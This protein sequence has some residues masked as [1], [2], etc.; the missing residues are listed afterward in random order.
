MIKLGTNTINKIYL[1]NSIVQK[2]Y[3]GSELV[4]PSTQIWTPAELGVSLALWLDADDSS[5][6]TL[7]GSTVS[8]WRDKS[9]NNRHAN[10]ATA[11]KQPLYLTNGINGR[12][13]LS[14]DGNNKSLFAS[15]AVINLPQPFSRFIAGQ[16]LSKANKSVLI[17]TDTSNNQGVFYNG[18]GGANWVVANG[19]APSFAAYS[20]GT[21]DFLNHQHM[22]IINGAAS[23]WGL[24]G[25]NI[26]GPV[27]SGPSG[28]LGVRIGHV[29]TELSGGY[30]FQGLVSEIVFVSGVISTSDRQKLEGYLAWKWGTTANLPSGHPYKINPPTI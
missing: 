19:V 4:Y 27:N 26:T 23:Y 14:F 17:D 22:H 11:A 20:Y 25:S 2:I 5:T 21:R 13:V 30:A 6:I 16:F 18:E 1:G 9:G 15:S 8:Q 3:L 28:Q 10:Q 7:N 29:R 12:N 24:D